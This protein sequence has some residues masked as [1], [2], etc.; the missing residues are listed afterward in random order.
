MTWAFFCL[1]VLILIQEYV[2]VFFIGFRE[3][4]QKRERNI[5]LLPPLHTSTG[6]GTHNLDMCPDRDLNPQPFGA[7]DDTPIYCTTWP[8]LTWGYLNRQVDE[9]LYLRIVFSSKWAIDQL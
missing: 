4:G 5:D 7:G 6:D 3:K 8:G 2:G 9:P 1:F